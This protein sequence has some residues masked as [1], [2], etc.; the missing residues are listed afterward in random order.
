M[1]NYFLKKELKNKFKIRNKIT[2][3]LNKY[4]LFHLIQQVLTY[5]LQCQ[6]V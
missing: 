1:S 4:I 6:F 3:N 2:L 5:S